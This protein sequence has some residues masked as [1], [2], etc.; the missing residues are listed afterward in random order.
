MEEDLVEESVGAEG[1]DGASQDNHRSRERHDQGEWA[2]NGARSGTGA[3][4]GRGGLAQEEDQ[5]SNEVALGADGL[6]EEE[7]EEM[8]EEERIL[9][10]EEARLGLDEELY[11]SESITSSAT[12]SLTWISWFCSLPGHEYFAEV[13]E[14]FIEDD[15]NLTGLNALVPF[16]KE[17]LEMILDVEPQ[18][19]S[20]KI[21]DVSIVES[22]AEL[23]YGLIH[24]RFILTR[25]GLS[26][27]AEKYEAGHFGYCPRVF[28][29]S[30]PVLPCGRSD[31]PGLDTVKLFCPNCIDNYS[32]PS[33]RFHGVDGAFFGT[34]FPHLLFQSFREMAPSP[35]APKGSNQLSLNTQSSPP[36]YILSL[37][38]QS[39]P[40]EYIVGGS[41]S[42]E[43]EE[44]RARE[45]ADA[46][47]GGTL[48][49]KLLGTKTPASRLYTPRIYGFRVSELAKSGPRMRWMRMR[50]ESF[51]EL[52]TGRLGSGSVAARGPS[53]VGAGVTAAGGAS[54]FDE[55]SIAL[56]KCETGRKDHRAEHYSALLASFQAQ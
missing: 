2:E 39:S 51:Q 15:F 7:E 53:G 55:A 24:Q 11:E 54:A 47:L 29:H 44:E 10:E 3:G 17:A 5:V 23:L 12:D 31:L 52:E 45:A 33:S 41:V 30:H 4:A 50:P 46:P 48:D 25:Q 21:P 56:T 9:A 22:S 49:P 16:Y 18:E 14:E 19:D 38:T 26:Q 35:I 34:T 8:N 32:P 6:P 43:A 37:N 13:A 20:L 27:M 36:E 42:P 28:C 1:A 40:P